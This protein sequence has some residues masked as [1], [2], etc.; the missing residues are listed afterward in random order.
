MLIGSKKD[1][2]DVREVTHAEAKAWAD[3]NGA[4]LLIFLF[5]INQGV[6]FME[7]SSKTYDLK[8]FCIKHFKS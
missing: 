6:M 2:E 7:T 1:L 4:Y 8:R 5:S 3:E